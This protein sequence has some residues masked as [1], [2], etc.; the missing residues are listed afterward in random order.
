MAAAATAK[1]VFDIQFAMVLPLLR[2]GRPET[3]GNRRMH[4]DADITFAQ[5]SNKIYIESMRRVT[6]FYDA[7]MRHLRTIRDDSAARSAL[8]LRRR[9]G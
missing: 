1:P 3:P 8:D 6:S 5:S 4:T 2:A 7:A 9:R